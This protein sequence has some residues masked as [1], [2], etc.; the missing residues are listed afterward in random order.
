MLLNAVIGISVIGILLIGVKDYIVEKRAA[1]I[2]NN[3]RIAIALTPTKPPITPV[4]TV[5][6]IIVPCA[7]QFFTFKPGALWNYQMISDTVSKD[8]KKKHIASN[9]VIKMTTVATGEATLEITSLTEKNSKTATIICR[10]DGLYWNPLTLVSNI[11]NAS[12]LLQMLDIKPIL[13]ITSSEDLLHKDYTWTSSLRAD[14]NLGFIKQS[15]EVPL[16]N[17]VI[18]E[19]TLRK[20]ITVSS[21]A[22]FGK[23]GLDFL[24][25]GGNLKFVYE[26]QKNNGIREASAEAKMAPFIDYN[27]TIKRR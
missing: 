18:S 22:N 20:S 1:Q 3:I 26:L 24:V 10:A 25:K 16:T 21:T 15:I 14:I 4:Q 9:I 8:G 17:K 13:L 19:N 23:S 6:P 2:Q 5:Q 7:S 11:G 12:G 27:F